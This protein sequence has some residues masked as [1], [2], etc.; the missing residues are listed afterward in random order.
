VSDVVFG[1]LHPPA[2][3]KALP[4]IGEH[5]RPDA[6]FI[7]LA[8]VIRI[9]ALRTVLGGFERIARMIPNVASIVGSGFNP[10]SLSEAIGPDDKLGLLDW[11]LALGECPRCPTSNS[12][13]TRS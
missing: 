3:K 4:R 10:I 2:M 8:P 1:A 6:I 9:S 5:L 11:L 12:K 13:P 7:S